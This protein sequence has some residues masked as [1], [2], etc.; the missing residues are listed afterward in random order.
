MRS[1]NV[2]FNIRHMDI[3]T[4]VRSIHVTKIIDWPD[5]HISYIF[6]FICCSTIPFYN[7]S[8]SVYML[9][10]LLAVFMSK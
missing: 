3:K 7:D 6:S 10:L 5:Y 8:F 9:K 1:I 2:I 4:N